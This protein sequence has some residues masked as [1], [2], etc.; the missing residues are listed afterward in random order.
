MSTGTFV[1]GDA[2]DASDWR[3]GLARFGLAAKGVLYITLGVLAFRLGGSGA[4]GQ[5][6]Q[7]GAMQTIKNQP[8]GT[9][10]L[11]LLALGLLAH[12]VW[13]LVI[14]FTGDPVEGGEAKQRVKYAVKTV[15]YLGLGGLAIT[16]LL[17]SGSSGGS[18]GSGGG[19]SQATATLLGM[20]GGVWIAGAIGV[21]IVL[22]ALVEFVRHAVRTQFMERIN[23]TGH[24]DIRRNVRRAGRAGYA[25]HAV[26]LLITG[27]FLVVAAVEHD[28]SESRGLN[29]ALQALAAQPWGAWLLGA[30]AVGL[31]LYGVFALAE[32]RYR[33]AG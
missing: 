15:I 23:R 4:G 1:G 5:A 31:A 7:S 14:T 18:G 3:S 24:G 2:V 25:A 9:W 12:G 32:A 6:S 27:G 16:V 8:A 13:Q 20:P 29:G 19:S 28:A 21:V 33:R 22:V 11:G 10:L 17:G 26:V 30:V